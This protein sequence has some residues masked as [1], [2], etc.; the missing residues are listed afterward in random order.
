[1]RRIPLHIVRRLATEAA[2][3]AV[4]RVTLALPHRTLVKDAEVRQVDMQTSVGAVG[5]LAGHTPAVFEVRPGL[6]RLIGP[7]SNTDE[8]AYFVSGGFAVVEGNSMN[9][10]AMEGAEVE[11]LD[12]A[13]VDR[14]MR[15]LEARGAG[16]TDAER[17]EIEIHREVFSALASAV[18]GLPK[19]QQ[20][21]G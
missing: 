18:A 2:N 8:K 13:A 11:R 10:A 21:S 6:V 3:S 12:P 1:M 17:A 4:L 7:A 15:A 14:G 5:V 20:S 19:R 9:V 16:S